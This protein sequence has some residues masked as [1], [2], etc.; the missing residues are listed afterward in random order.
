MACTQVAVGC[1][2]CKWQYGVWHAG[3]SRCQG[4]GLPCEW[5]YWLLYWCVSHIPPH[6]HHFTDYFTYVRVLGLRVALRITLLITLRMCCKNRGP[7]R[8]LYGSPRH[9]YGTLSTWCHLYGTPCMWSI[10][11]TFYIMPSM[12]N[13]FYMIYMEHLLKINVP[14]VDVKVH[15]HFVDHWLE[16]MFAVLLSQLPPLAR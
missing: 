11:N 6:T 8:Y 10:R 9:V 1:V 14:A 15:E 16:V 4:W 2:A 12:W 3:G 13:T 7:C 5:L